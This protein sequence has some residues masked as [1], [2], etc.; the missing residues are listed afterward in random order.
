M[1]RKTT[2]SAVLLD[3]H[4]LWLEAVESVLDSLEIAVVGK[5][6]T[7]EAALSMLDEHQ[8]DILLVETGLPG[9]ISGSAL[10]REARE[11]LPAIR[12][13]A[14]ASSAEP[15]DID[16]AFDAGVVAYVVKTAHPQDIASTVRQAF[17]HSIFLGRV[18]PDGESPQLRTHHVVETDDGA[19]LTPREREILALVTEGYSNRELAKRLWVTE[20]TVKFHLSNIYRKLGVTNR[21]EASRWAHK[22]RLVGG[23]EEAV[24]A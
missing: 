4:P 18:Q 7:A 2:H 24:S 15:A 19:P 13:I 8:P 6:G 23:Q 9:A 1:L 20:Q 5:A 17:D 12:V 3:P 10:V 22:H 21:T 14:L 11:R 16:A